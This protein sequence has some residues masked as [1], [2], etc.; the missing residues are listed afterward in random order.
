MGLLEEIN[1]RENLDEALCRQLMATDPA[2]MQG[3]E[4]IH[5]K[6]QLLAEVFDMMRLKGGQSRN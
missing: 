4:I 3:R 5:L 2:D 6:R 1:L